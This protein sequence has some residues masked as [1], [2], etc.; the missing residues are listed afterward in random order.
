MEDSKTEISWVGNNVQNCDLFF[1]NGSGLEWLYR[2]TYGY[3]GSNPTSFIAYVVANNTPTASIFA[4]GY[5]QYTAQNQISEYLLTQSGDTL[6]LNLYQYDSD[7]FLV[8]REQKSAGGSPGTFSIDENNYYFQNTADLTEL[9]KVKV[10][11]YPNPAIDQLTIQTDGNIQS[12]QILNLSGQVLLEQK[13]GELNIAHLAAGTYILRG[14]T[15]KG[16]F[17]ETII[18]R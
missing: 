5:F 16:S 12:V 11:V 3:T 8:K 14:S 1:D 4:N 7:G 10:L 6:G 13:S 18:K 2:V 9:D 15:D 17:S